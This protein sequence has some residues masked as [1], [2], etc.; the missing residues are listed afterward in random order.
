M[1]IVLDLDNTLV[2]YANSF[3]AVADDM[4]LAIPKAMDKASFKEL[5]VTMHGESCW[6]LIQGRVY[7]PQMHLARPF[8]N[9]DNSMIL[10]KDKLSEIFIVSHRSKFSHSK[11]AHEL[12][13]VAKNWVRDNLSFFGFSSFEHFFLEE[14]LEEKIYRIN[15]LNPDLIID[16]LMS[17]LTHKNLNRNFKR[18][19]FSPKI[20]YVQEGYE[21][22]VQMRDWNEFPTLVKGL[23]L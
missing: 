11:E 4:G 5:V 13:N 10:V 16:D 12:H 8:Q 1:R 22:I 15:S 7:G 23:C 19:L 14:T 3:S 20:N 9:L 6:T 2:N 18:I 17:V 21:D